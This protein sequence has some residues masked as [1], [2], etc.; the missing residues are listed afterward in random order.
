ME[1]ARKDKTMS[2][3]WEDF[4]AS[5][6]PPWELFQGGTAVAE[7]PNATANTEAHPTTGATSNEFTEAPKPGVAEEYLQNVREDAA[8]SAADRKAAGP[9]TK[10]AAITQSAGASVAGG[11]GEDSSPE[12]IGLK[13]MDPRF[14]PTQR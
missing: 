9:E 5:A 3:P 11:K 12:V 13:L 14:M 1:E 6:V 8:Q 4:A 2:K 7:A 10:P